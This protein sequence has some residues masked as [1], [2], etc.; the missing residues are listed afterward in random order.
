MELGSSYLFFND[1]ITKV[2][3]VQISS[4]IVDIRKFDSYLEKEFLSFCIM[5][6]YFVFNFGIKERRK[7]QNRFL[8]VLQIE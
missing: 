8:T 2:D 6:F 3:V 1:Q 5:I 7:P 4:I